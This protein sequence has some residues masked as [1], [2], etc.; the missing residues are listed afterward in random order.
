[1]RSKPSLVQVPYVRHTTPLGISD[2]REE[3]IITVLILV[4]TIT[5][6]VYY[7]GT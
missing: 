1:M 7:I 2:R 4:L 3:V 6:E 5:K